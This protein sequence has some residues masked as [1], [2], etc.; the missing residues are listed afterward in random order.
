VN[1]NDPGIFISVFALGILAVSIVGTWKMFAKAGEPGWA[2][3]IPIY[4]VIVLLRIA[5][6]PLWWILLYLI[7]LVNL[8][9]AIVVMVDLA[10]CFGKGAG[11]GLGLMFLGFIFFPI[12]GLGEAQYSGPA[13]NAFA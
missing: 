3:L 5:G 10:R 9:V 11:F 4:N 7:P 13:R 12:L 1:N 8:V 6:R 2:C